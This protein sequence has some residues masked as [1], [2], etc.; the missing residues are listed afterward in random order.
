MKG[1]GSN[2]E[3]EGRKKRYIR[4]KKRET[5]KKWSKTGIKKEA[6]QKDMKLLKDTASGSD[7]ILQLD[8]SGEKIIFT[9]RN[10]K[11]STG[12]HEKRKQSDFS[13]EI[14]L[15]IAVNPLEA[16]IL[17]DR[18]EIFNIQTM[19]INLFK[20]GRRR[21]N[22]ISVFTGGKGCIRGTAII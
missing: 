16:T 19:T 4:A 12:N 1:T 9:N 18:K 5:E 13:I 20:S 10:G 3:R 7:E 8:S 15:G 2:D 17:G 14:F 21:I 11:R 6:D 22:P